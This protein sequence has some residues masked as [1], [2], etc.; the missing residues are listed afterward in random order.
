MVKVPKSK[1]GRHS[2]A[3][4]TNRFSIL[5]DSSNVKR[6]NSNPTQ[7][8]DIVRRGSCMPSGLHGIILE[9]D[10]GFDSPNFISEQ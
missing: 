5:S 8:K 4:K 3:I 7:K 9:D 6:L 10:Q 1:M 2:S